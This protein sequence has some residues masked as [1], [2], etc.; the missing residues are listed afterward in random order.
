MTGDMAG[1]EA[2]VGTTPLDCYVCVRMRGKIAAAGRDWPTAEHWF[3]E[4][5]RQGPS[6]PMAYSDW[7]EML[8]AKGDPA[9]AIAK[10]DLAHQKGPRFADP[11][12]GWGDALARQ[13]QW[14]DAL[15]KYDEALKDAPAWQ[16]L[17][18]ARD[19]AARRAS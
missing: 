3:A 2:L 12:K 4:A 6:I 18:Q 8:L 17:H 11:L 5:V 15:A 7:G 13:G 16:A 1:A 14:S 19:A 10:F 9:G